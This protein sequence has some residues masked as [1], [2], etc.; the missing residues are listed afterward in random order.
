LV[1]TFF[2]ANKD[3]RLK[4]TGGELRWLNGRFMLVFGHR[5]DG[6]YSASLADYNKLKGCSRPTPK[7]CASSACDD[8]LKLG[9]VQFEDG[10]FDA[11]GAV[12]SP[13]LSRRRHKPGRR[14]TPG[15]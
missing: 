10:G 4:V 7:R 8:Q 15:C 13:R 5:F 11:T 2:L 6:F 1:K 9:D 12:P 3:E 14:Q